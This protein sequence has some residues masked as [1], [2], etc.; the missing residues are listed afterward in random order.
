MDRAMLTAEMSTEI[1]GVLGWLIAK[2]SPDI[3]N[4]YVTLP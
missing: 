2:L 4:T 3:D 1:K